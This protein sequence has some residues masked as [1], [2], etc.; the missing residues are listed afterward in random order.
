MTAHLKPCLSLSLNRALSDAF[1]WP[2]DR[3]VLKIWPQARFFSAFCRR[4]LSADCP[5]LLQHADVVH[6][7]T[8]T[9]LSALSPLRS[10]GVAE[11]LPAEDMLELCISTL[12]CS[13]STNHFEA[14][15]QKKLHTSMQKETL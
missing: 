2:T 10:V 12:A 9:V 13:W 15:D 7:S 6:N 3:A 14:V 8:S 4:V 5:M 1:E 11:L